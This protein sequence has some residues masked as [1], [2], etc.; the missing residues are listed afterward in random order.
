MGSGHVGGDILS[1][2]GRRSM[3]SSFDALCV[4][5]LGLD[6]IGRW[7]VCIDSLDDLGN[8]T[9]GILTHIPVYLC[10]NYLIYASIQRNNDMY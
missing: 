4:H 1:M 7:Y 9:C 6:G 3:L 2:G 10:I 8:H 5:L